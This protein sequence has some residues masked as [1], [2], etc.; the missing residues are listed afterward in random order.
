MAKEEEQMSKIR[1]MAKERNKS[2]N[3]T[4]APPAKRMKMTD[5]TYTTNLSSSTQAPNRQ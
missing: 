1:V 2:R 4:K 5:S 3:T